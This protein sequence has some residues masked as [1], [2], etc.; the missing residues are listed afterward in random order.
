MTDY[1]CPSCGG[2]CRRSGC[3]RKDVNS[4]HTLAQDA[5]R[6]EPEQ[7]PV[8]YGMWDTMVGYG[9]R[10]MMVRLDKGQDGC[11]IPLYTIPPQRKPLSDEQIWDAY[12]KAPVDIDCH[13]SDLHKFARAIEAAHNIKE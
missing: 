11:T 4:T 2:F 9:G 12:M 10:M 13:V 6:K 5:Q 3:E 8:A 7:K 1:Q